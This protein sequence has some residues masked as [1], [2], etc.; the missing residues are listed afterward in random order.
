MYC[1]YIHTQS[2]LPNLFGHFSKLLR[3]TATKHAQKI[4]NKE[5]KLNVKERK[6]KATKSE[7]QMA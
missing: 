5:W 2:K 4:W 6:P 1:I 7:M 3:K